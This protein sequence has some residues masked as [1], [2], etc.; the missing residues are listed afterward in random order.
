MEAPSVSHLELPE[1]E[2]P[3]FLTTPFFFTTTFTFL[4]TVLVNVL[5]Y[6]LRKLTWQ[7]KIHH[8]K[9]YFLLKMGISNVMLVSRGVPSLKLT[10]SPMQIDGWK[11]NFPFGMV[12][13]QGRTV[14]GGEVNSRG[15]SGLLFMGSASTT[16]WEV[17]VNIVYLDVP[18]S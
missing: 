6:T 8:L 11:I 3:H 2:S 17:K 5:W 16:T 15:N 10:F 13:F 18:G 14:F 4:G 12:C 7:W 1:S 9:M